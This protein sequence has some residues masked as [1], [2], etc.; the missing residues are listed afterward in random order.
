MK[1]RAAAILS[2]IVVGILA[3][4]TGGPRAA[5]QQQLPLWVTFVFD[6]GYSHV[7]TKKKG[8]E[9][10]AFTAPSDAP[11]ATH[12]HMI[13]RLLRGD[14][15]AGKPPDLG[16]PRTQWTLNRQD[17]RLASYGTAVQD[18]ITPPRS[19]D[20]GE[21]KRCDEITDFDP[22]ANNW[23]FLPSMKKLGSNGKITD[24]LSRFTGRILLDHGRVAMRRVKGCWDFK[25]E[26]GRQQGMRMALIPGISALKYNLEPGGDSIELR[27]SPVGR[28]EVTDTITLK[29]ER[30]EENGIA[31]N[32]IMIRAGRFP[33]TYEP[34]LPN[35][36]QMADFKR[37]YTLL[38]DPPSERKRLIPHKEFRAMEASP[39]DE[40]AGALFQQP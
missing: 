20:P 15:T 34:P 24:D 37:Y 3:S 35:G 18:G 40:C 11:D 9:V 31:R 30:V 23:F 27:L 14:Q 12:H 2:C 25:S 38:K 16:A 17:V 10:G 6:G 32:E 28:M 1:M 8:L 19:R 39:G 13:L 36:A 7:V 26:D 4:G 33:A 21:A 29:A 5:A 22:A